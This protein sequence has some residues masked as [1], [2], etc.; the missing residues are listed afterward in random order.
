MYDPET[1]MFKYFKSASWRQSEE[2]RL[3][4]YIE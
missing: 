3:S 1:K 4:E 2:V